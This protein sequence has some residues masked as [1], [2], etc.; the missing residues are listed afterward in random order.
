MRSRHELTFGLGVFFFAALADEPRRT[1]RMLLDVARQADQLGLDFLSTP[2]RHFHRFGGAFPNAAVTSAAIAATTERI[3]IRAGSVISP[4]HPTVR[5][6]ED[7]AVV[8]C[9][10]GGRAAISLG[11]GWNVNDFV[12]DTSAFRS[13]RERVL[14][15]VTAI[16]DAWQSGVWTAENPN[17]TSVELNI[18]PRPVTPLIPI[19]ITASRSVE[20]FRHAG[21][22]DVN[23]LTHLEN[24]DIDDLAAKISVYRGARTTP[25]GKVTVM[26]HTYITD[27]TEQA[28][29]I[30]GPFLKRY[31]KTALDLE[32]AAVNA[33]GKMSGGRRARAVMFD[34]GA[35]DRAVELA[36]NRYFDGA[37]FIGSETQCLDIARRLRDIGVDEIACLVDFI[38]DPELVHDSIARLARVHDAMS[39]HP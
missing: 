20:T 11:S 28:R 19:W 33:G 32:T 26:L 21:E 35:R 29:A 15:D 38:D 27:S 39:A 2:E 37:S 4:L 6:I 9:I 1:Y 10:S 30:A 8:D 14:A 18:Y 16:R 7:F 23:V 5:V 12:I 3:Q 34:P 17:G 24:Q 22:L 36:A 25:G 31:I 13:R